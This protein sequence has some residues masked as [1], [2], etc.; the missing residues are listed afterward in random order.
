MIKH[1]ALLAGF[2]VGATAMVGGVAAQWQRLQP[3]FRLSSGTTELVIAAPSNAELNQRRVQKESDELQKIIDDFTATYHGNVAVVATDLATGASASVNG[4]MQ[5]V[6]ASVYKLFVAWGIYQ[7]VDAGQLS[8]N[9]KTTVGGQTVA[10]CLDV[11]I[12]ISDNDCGYA[13]GKI[14]G[15]AALDAQLAAKGYTKTK[16]NNYDKSGGLAGDKMTS[17]NDVSRFVV[18]LYRGELL[19]PASTE[20]FIALLKADKLNTWLPSGLPEGT[21]IAHK[22]GALYNVVH[23][24]GV[25]YSGTGDYTVV[26]MTQGWKNAV[27]QPPAVF[28]DISRQLWDFFTR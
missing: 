5:M 18:A 6:S 15:W 8:L 12:T 14:A 28:A 7:K 9:S 22:T 13:L 23:D 21:V 16:I 1:A 20:A 25:V 17:A 10:Q 4:D 11:M 3:Q 2:A 24:A 19:S 26:V 27:K